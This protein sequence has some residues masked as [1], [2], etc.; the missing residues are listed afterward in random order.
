MK[1]IKQIVF[2]N[3]YVA[4]YVSA[5]EIDLE[6]IGANQV[7]VQTYVSTVS[8]GTERANF[9]GDPNVKA[10]RN[11][12]AEVKFPR[13]VGYSSAG[14][15]VAVGS[16]VT[17]VGVGDRVVVYWGQHKTYN[18]IPEECVVKIE[19]D[20][21]SYE[22]A[23]ISFIATFPLA[24][25]RK[26]KVE[27]GESLMV[28]GLGLLGQLAVMFA[29]AM[30]AYP[31]IACDPIAARREEALKNGADYA[32]DPLEKDFEEKVRAV[33]GGVNAAIEVTGVGAGLN[34]TLDCMAKFGRVALLG[35]TRNSDFSIDYY[36]KV[37]G[38]GITLVG[39][40]TMARPDVESHPSYFTHNDDIKATLKMCLGGRLSLKSLIKET[41]LPSECQ[42]I[43]MRL[44]TD[45]NFPLVV[46]FDWRKE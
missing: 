39:A 19:D 26:V 9:V 32:F 15:V 18:V 29:R 28:M 4:E 42:E 3:P 1:E 41:H 45:K 21:I 16:A 2:T 5:G 35:C 6:K 31:V 46:Q 23:A 27:L 43:Y 22:E 24:A 30:G 17:K 11:A 14:K 40:H 38:P 25:L 33:C 36:H 37:H 20:S 12:K 10:E 7:A 8:P 13:Y 44:A 34:E